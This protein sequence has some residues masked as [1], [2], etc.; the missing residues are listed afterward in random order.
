MGGKVFSGVDFK[1]PRT[2]ATE[3]VVCRLYYYYV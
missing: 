3:R 1:N 2:D